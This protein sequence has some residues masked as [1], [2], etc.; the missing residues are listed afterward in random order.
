MG[1]PVTLVSTN[2]ISGSGDM[3]PWAQSTSHI[4]CRNNT[5]PLLDAVHNFFLC[6][7]LGLELLNTWLTSQVVSVEET[8][9]MEDEWGPGAWRRAESGSRKRKS[10]WGRSRT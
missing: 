3:P 7:H 10:I 1:Q 5:H 9:Q 6:V 4:F 2:Y 8:E